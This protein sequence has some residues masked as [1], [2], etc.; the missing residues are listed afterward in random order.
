MPPTR[1]V[2]AGTTSC[3]RETAKCQHTRR[4]LRRT[5]ASSIA[6]THTQRKPA[7][8]A[9]TPYC[10]TAQTAEPASTD[11]KNCTCARQTQHKLAG[12]TWHACTAA[13]CATSTGGAS[14]HHTLQTQQPACQR[15]MQTRQFANRA[16]GKKHA[17]L[18]SGPPASKQGK[19][20]QRPEGRHDTA[21]KGITHRP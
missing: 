19:H 2:P 11:I 18:S 4:P 12:H 10:S 13:R 3:T 14:R 15:R 21:T 6:S 7:S 16:G 17:G 1:T 5:P 9:G 8:R 20:T